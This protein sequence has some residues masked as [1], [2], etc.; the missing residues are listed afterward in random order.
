MNILHAVVMSI[1]L[2]WH[3]IIVG[4]HADHSVP[5]QIPPS[6][7]IIVRNTDF[8]PREERPDH[9]IFP[10]TQESS[11]QKDATF[12]GISIKKMADL[13]P[14]AMVAACYQQVPNV[15]IVALGA[16][17]VGISL[18]NSVVR[19][20]VLSCYHFYKKW[21]GVLKEKVHKTYVL[22]EQ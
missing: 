5:Q 14:F 12:L 4:S 18:K 7:N 19:K 21:L 17:L 15:T 11:S 6:V 16:I 20:K 1:V 2:H 9:S 8:L 3:C 10:G 13:I 22:Y